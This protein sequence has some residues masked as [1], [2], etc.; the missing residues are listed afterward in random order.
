M[1]WDV[2]GNI[3]TQHLCQTNFI[4][5]VVFCI[6]FCFIFLLFALGD[7]VI[8]SLACRLRLQHVQRNGMLQL[9]HDAF[10]WCVS[11]RIQFL[12][13]SQSSSTDADLMPSSHPASEKTLWSTSSVTQFFGFFFPF[14]TGVVSWF[15]LSPC[16][17]ETYQ[18][19]SIMICTSSKLS[20]KK[21]T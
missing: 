19:S 14:H 12:L 9:D 13:E 3:Q 17:I 1:R 4:S 18:S 7:G 15:P 10:D 5:E 2:Q 16:D 11:A 21:S 20:L 8:Q 6:L